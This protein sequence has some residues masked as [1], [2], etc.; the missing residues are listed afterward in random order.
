MGHGFAMV[1]HK[2]FYFGF[3]FLL[4]NLVDWS[5]NHEPVSD[6]HKTG[7]GST[8]SLSLGQKL[9]K[10]AQIISVQIDVVT[11]TTKT[12]GSDHT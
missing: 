9:Q 5:E 2:D 8:L 1:S 3:S 4:Y 6:L 10:Q 7:L 11:V 12:L